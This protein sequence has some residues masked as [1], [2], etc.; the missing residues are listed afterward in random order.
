MLFRSVWTIE[1]NKIQLLEKHRYLFL[2]GN[3][4]G[5][6][7]V[8]KTQISIIGSEII[9]LDTI[10]ICNMTYDIDV[11]AQWSRGAKSNIIIKLSNL[12]KKGRITLRAL[13]TINEI[14]ITDYSIKGE[15]NINSISSFI[16]DNKYNIENEI[17]LKLIKPFK[18]E[19]NLYGKSAETF[20]D[21]VGSSFLIKLAKFGNNLFLVGEPL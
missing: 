11:T 2:L 7:R 21:R 10:K 1:N 14:K 3:K 12:S 13:Y 20:F 18:Y 9:N 5:W 4:I 17:K 8:N 19:K 15:E 6:A 16:N